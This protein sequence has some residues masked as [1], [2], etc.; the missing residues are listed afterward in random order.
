MTKRVAA[1]KQNSKEQLG[2]GLV[3]EK[4]MVF[5]LL[6]QS[7]Y[8]N[9]YHSNHSSNKKNGNDKVDI[10]NI[11][12]SENSNSS[13]GRSSSRGSNGNAITNVNTILSTSV[14]RLLAGYEDGSIT[15]FDIRTLK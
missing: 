4:G 1:I 15:C 3:A 10:A 9:T 11:E 5:S 7:Q 2:A 12:S 13:G 14:P 8:G 6:L